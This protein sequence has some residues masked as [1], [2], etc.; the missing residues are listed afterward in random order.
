MTNEEIQ[1]F[2]RRI[3][4]AN[5]TE[6]LVIL[7]DIGLTY[8]EDAARALEAGDKKEFRLQIV[9]VKNTIRELMNSVNTS[10]EPGRT[11]MSVYVF[12]NEELTRAFADCSTVNLENVKKILTSFRDTYMECSKKDTDG[13]VMEHTETVYTGL[14]YNRNSYTDTVSVADAGRGFLV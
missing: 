6:M 11:I 4:N 14:T 13:A 5:K 10:V 3:A 2:T 12:C 7:Y 1:V 9:R 8:I